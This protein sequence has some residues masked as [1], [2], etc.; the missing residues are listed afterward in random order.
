M[1]KKLIIIIFVIIIIIGVFVLSLFKR[2]DD[3][4]EIKDVIHLYISY[5]RGYMA[6]SNVIYS[7]DYNEKDNKY[8]VSIKPYLKDDDDKLEK[9]VS[10]EFSDEIKKILIKYNV[11][12]WNGFKKYADNVLDGDSFSFHVRM[13]DD[14]E[15]EADGYMSW[16]ENYGNVISEFDNLLMGIYSKDKKE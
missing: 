9:E 7:F 12:N 10:K 8:I 2:K 16:P 15:I 14:E 11:S 5:S 3:K 1:N 6:N 4:V 13:V